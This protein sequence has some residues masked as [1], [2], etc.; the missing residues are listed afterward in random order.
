MLNEGL[1]ATD[2]SAA[3]RSEMIRQLQKLGAATPDQ[4]ERA[5]FERLTGHRREDVDWDV[6]GNQAGYVTWVKT[7][8]QHVGELIA[9]GFVREVER[10]GEARL[11]A[12][13]TDPAIEWSMLVSPTR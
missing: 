8:E 3:L 1:F 6:E 5:V 12:R 4:W 9:D 11:E 2:T 10:E 7:F 13:E